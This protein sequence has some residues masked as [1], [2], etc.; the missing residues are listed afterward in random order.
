MVCILLCKK[1]A[2]VVD[3]YVYFYCTVLFV[4]ILLQVYVT[5]KG[6][7]LFGQLAYQQY[8]RVSHSGWVLLAKWRGSPYSVSCTRTYG[9]FFHGCINIFPSPESA[10]AS[11]SCVVTG[12]RK[13]R[14]REGW[15]GPR[16]SK[17]IEESLMGYFTLL[18][19]NIGP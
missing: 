4:Y 13:G 6:A 7:V 14:G 19:Q 10:I 9:M 1:C 3:Y 18:L 8:R 15:E 5:A 17:E 2:Q 11:P 16:W 12:L